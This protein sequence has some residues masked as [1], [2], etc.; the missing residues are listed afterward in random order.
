MNIT[1]ICAD[2]RNYF[3]VHR[4]NDIH[5]GHFKISGR[6]IAPLDFLQK[7]QYFRIVGSTM[8][9]GVYQNTPESKHTLK[10][11]EFDGAVWA[12]SVPPAFIMLCEDIETWRANHE[13][14][15][16]QNMSPFTSE[17][18][19]GYTYSKGATSSVTWQEQF[20]GRLNAYRRIRIL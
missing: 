17:S 4:E 8:N 6:D 18:F 10:N 19:G 9:D 3:L 7:G 5:K 13:S 2:I 15:G 16:S 11:E 14:V 12:M 1:E 20:K